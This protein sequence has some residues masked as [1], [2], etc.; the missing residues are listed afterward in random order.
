[1]T[2]KEIFADIDKG[3]EKMPGLKFERRDILRK[4]NIAQREIV[5]YTNATKKIDKT[6]VS[7][8]GQQ[9]YDK[10]ADCLKLLRVTYIGKKLFNISKAG[11][12]IA[13][14]NGSISDPWGTETGTPTHY[15][16]EELG[17]FG[18]YPIPDAAGDE[19]AREYIYMVEDL[20]DDDND[21]PFDDI[22]QLYPYHQ[23]LITYVFWQCFMVAGIEYESKA[24]SYE[25][26]YKTGLEVLRRQLKVNPDMLTTFSL[27]RR[28]IGTSKG[29]LPSITG[30]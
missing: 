12:D 20:V 17:K 3:L 26:D 13:V 11:L 5:T 27:V 10:P 23:L 25:N 14:A 7:V 6:L 18:L 4:L 22:K 24:N 19:I 28:S 30:S 2:I 1:M 21:I 8:I 29:A 9:E 15:Y 16:D